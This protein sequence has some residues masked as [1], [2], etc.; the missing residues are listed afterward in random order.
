MLKELVGTDDEKTEYGL[1]MVLFTCHVKKPSGWL[2]V[3]ANWD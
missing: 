3:L 1:N 2:G